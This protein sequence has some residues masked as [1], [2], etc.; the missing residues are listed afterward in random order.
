MG[1]QDSG[2][3][4]LSIGNALSSAAQGGAGEAPIGDDLR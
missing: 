1:F 4:E 3:V 2:Q